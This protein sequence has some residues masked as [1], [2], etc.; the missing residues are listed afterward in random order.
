MLGELFVPLSMLLR[1][2]RLQQSACAGAVS[3]APNA[4]R[5]DQSEYVQRDRVE[6]MQFLVHA[7]GPMSEGYL[8]DRNAV[9]E[10]KGF[11]GQSHFRDMC[12][13]FDRKQ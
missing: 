5:I 2:C 10:V 9:E 12:S 13:E 6:M 7:V 11:G 3:C 8:G 1:Q 4:L